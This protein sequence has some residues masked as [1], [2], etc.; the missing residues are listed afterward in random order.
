MYYVLKKKTVDISLQSLQL[1]PL[2]R[3]ILYVPYYTRDVRGTAVQYNEYI[4]NQI[5]FSFLPEK[6]IFYFVKGVRD[7]KDPV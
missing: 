5:N 3:F 1:Y 4:C 7:G 6:Y 2:R